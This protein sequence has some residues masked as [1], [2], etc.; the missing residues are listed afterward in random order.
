MQHPKT[1]TRTATGRVGRSRHR[2]TM[3][4]DTKMKNQQSSNIDDIERKYHKAKAEARDADLLMSTISSPNTNTNSPT[5][6]GIG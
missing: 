6:G 3:E 1:K 5:E 2:R 4:N